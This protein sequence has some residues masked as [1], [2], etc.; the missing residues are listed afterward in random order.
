MSSPGA[1]LQVKGGS[2]EGILSPGTGL[3]LQVYDS[4]EFPISTQFGAEL[5][6]GACAVLLAGGLD[7]GLG[8]P[9][10]TWDI[11]YYYPRLAVRIKMDDPSPL[12]LFAETRLGVRFTA[13]RVTALAGELGFA[14]QVLPVASLAVTVLDP[15]PVYACVASGYVLPLTGEGFI[16]VDTAKTSLPLKLRLTIIAGGYMRSGLLV[17]YPARPQ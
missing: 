17:L 15:P 9:A 8:V 12:E 3:Q 10:N 5:F 13:V 4:N 2:P 7:A 1:V 14:D 6:E 16:V 11:N